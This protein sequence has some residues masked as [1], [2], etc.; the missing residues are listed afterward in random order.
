MEHPIEMG[1]LGVFLDIDYLAIKNLNSNGNNGIRT[2]AGY[3]RH[4]KG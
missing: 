2:A 4:E 3:W 1:L